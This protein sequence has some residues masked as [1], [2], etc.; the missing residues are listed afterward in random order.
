M[1]KVPF[2][3]KQLGAACGV[4]ITALHNPKDDSG[5]KVYWENGVQICPPVD[6]AVARSIGKNQLMEQESWDE[7]SV[8][9]DPNV[10]DV[11]QRIMDAYFD[12]AA[13]GLVADHKARSY[14]ELH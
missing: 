5:Y 11:T 8:E 4:V 1:P 14:T 6:E 12:A 9:A 3:V 13:G 7:D 2:A 10:E